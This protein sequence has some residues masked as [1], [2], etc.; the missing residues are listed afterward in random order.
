MAKRLGRRLG[1]A[2]GWATVGLAVGGCPP[3]V[4]PPPAPTASASAAA[5]APVPPPPLAIVDPFA[6]GMTPAGVTRLCD[7]NLA[8]A[9]AL[10]ERLRTVDVTQPDSLSFERTF[11]TFDDVNLAI[12][13]AS[14]FPGLMAEVHPDKAVRDVAKD[15]Q[16]K[17]EKITTSLFLDPALY[18]VLRA[19]AD[20]HEALAPERARFVR[21]TLRDYRRNG[22]ELAADAQVRFRAMN[23]RL[24]ELGLGFSAAIGESKEAL[25]VAPAALEGL[26]ADYRKKHAAGPDGRV[27]IT[28]DYPDYI[29]FVTYAKDRK[30]ALDLY[31][32]MAN[33]GGEGNLRRLDEL[34][35]LRHEKALLLGYPTWADYA[36]EPR[37]ARTPGEARAF[38]QRIRDAV[39]EPA[40]RELA[41]FEAAWQAVGGDPKRPLYP[42]DRPYL[43]DRVRATRFKLD[44]QDLARYFDVARVTE[45]L[46]SL[47]AKM[48]GLEYRPVQQPLWHP[49]VRAFDVWS[50]GRPI[51]RFF[52]DLHSRDDKYKHA[53]MFTV[54]TRKRLADGSVQ[55][56]MAALVCNFP[57]PGDDMQHGEVVTFFH[58]FGHV[59]HQMLTE[60]E[61]SSYAGTAA[62]RDFVEAPSQ[63]FEEW[64]YAREILDLIAKHRESGQPIPD[65]LFEAM[66]KARRFGLALSTQRQ[67]T[68]ALVDL[69]Y[70]STPP[71]LDTTKVFADIQTDVEQFAFVPGTHFQSSFGHLIEY[72]AA[73]YGYQWAASLARDVLTRFQAE[74]LTNPKTAA[75][76][77]AAVL[78]RGGADDERE[79]VRRFLGR[80]T[81][82]QAYIAFL[83]GK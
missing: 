15:C 59:L 68:L 70:H 77:R 1:R 81:N 49:D 46:L 5:P 34:L 40:K 31:V 22:I 71:P 6:T 18:R 48:Y 14:S 11:G 55:L 69:A 53:A 8:L 2:L 36:I 57:R 52:L 76:W 39:R 17:T 63:M 10:L 58:E 30:A 47:T 28:T 21:D 51:A 33:R 67:L 50:G 56:P 44:T 79:M 42:P 72:D 82:E 64:P 13:N 19:Y 35:A 25:H 27:T 32:L 61:L 80:E 41:D 45:G 38:L 12:A 83:S 73:Y 23:E 20:R 74:G 75:D 16:R 9:E 54:R 60:T 26:P 65:A 43:E 7:D 24:T 29:P 66:G 4:T 3:P 37:M 78:A 62:V